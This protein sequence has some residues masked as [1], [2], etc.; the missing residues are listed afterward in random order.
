MKRE[1]LISASA[2]ESRVA[3]LED[4]RLVEFMFDRPD[5]GRIVGDIYWGRVEA[6]L[7]GIQASFVD[8]GTDK[9][10]F[11]HVSDVPLDDSELDDVADDSR[12][13]SQGRHR[14]GRR[15]GRGRGWQGNGKE[16]RR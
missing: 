11:L 8:I 7:P 5:Q 13:D 15:G 14:G 10:G 9:A 6:V 4:G 2:L 3:L 12:G 1:I 16:R